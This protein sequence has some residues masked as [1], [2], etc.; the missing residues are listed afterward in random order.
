MRRLER[1]ELLD[2]QIG[3][4]TAY[5][6][7]KIKTNIDARPGQFVML[8]GVWKEPILPRPFSIY[9]QDDASFTILMKIRGEATKKMS[10]LKRGDEIRF[11][12]PLGNPYPFF[13]DSR[14]IYL[15]AGGSG[16]APLHFFAENY[17]RRG[18]IVFL[19]GVDKRN[20]REFFDEVKGC[21]YEWAMEDGTKG[22]KTVLDLVKDY[23]FPADAVLIGCGPK[24]VLQT[25]LRIAKG[26]SLEAYVSLEEM[27]ACGIG[28]CKGCAVKVRE[29]NHIVVKHVCKDGPLFSA[30]EVLLEW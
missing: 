7:L 24:A 26:N 9:D 5:V 2:L 10:A 3:A 28:M 1:G 15:I 4:K 21:R 20:T 16:Y 17:P 19:T 6:K 13:P 18:N 25:I 30:K 8:K 22:Y 29:Q 14:R 11:K 23:S 12:G 27:M